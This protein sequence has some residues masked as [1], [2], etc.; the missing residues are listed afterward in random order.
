MSLVN[1]PRAKNQERVLEAN[2][3]SDPSWE[4][5]GIILISLVYPSKIGRYGDEFV[6][7]TEPS[8]IPFDYLK[9]LKHFPFFLC[10]FTQ[11]LMANQVGTVL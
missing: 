8:S 6:G 5:T 1:I 11:K 10:S 9:I 4:M 3:R 2:L 7:D